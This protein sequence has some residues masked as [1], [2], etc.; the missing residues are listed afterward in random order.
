MNRGEIWTVAGGVYASKP[1][2]AV[3]VQDDRFDGNDSVVVIPFTS[4]L[5]DAP[6]FRIPVAATATSGIQ[7]D[8]HLMVDKISAVRRVNV[9]DRLGRLTAGQLVDVERGMLVFLGLAD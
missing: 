9:R 7:R 6:L 5:V 2:P 8:S 4:T 1:R 3:I